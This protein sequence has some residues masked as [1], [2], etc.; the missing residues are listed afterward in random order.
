MATPPFH[1]PDAL[2]QRIADA[3]CHEK[4]FPAYQPIVCLRTRAI[5]GLEVLA[6]WHDPEWGNVPPK[7]FIP[8]ALQASLLPLLTL[9]LVRRACAEA[10]AWPGHFCLAFNVPPSLLQDAP[11]VRLLLEAMATSSFPLDR[12]CIEMTEDE[13]IED[14]AAA[15]RAFGYLKSHGIRVALDD[16]GTGFSSMVRLS[17]FG[18]DELKIDGSLIERLA[19]DRES[20][21]VVSA[22]IGLGHSLEVPVV[23][24]CVETEAQADVLRELGCDFVQGWLTGRPVSGDQAARLIAAAPVHAASPASLPLSPYLRQ[25]QLS[26]LYTNAP[27]GLAFLDLDMR[28][29]AANMQFARMAG[30]P[31]GEIVDAHVE[32]VYAPDIAAWILQASRRILDSGEVSRIEFRFPGREETFLVVGTR[33]TDET[34]QPIGVSVVTIDITDR[35][36]AEDEMRDR[37]ALYRA[38]VELG[39]NVLWVSGAD[40]TLTYISPAPQEPEG[41]AMEARMAAWYA[42]MH[43]DDV[44]RVRAEWS[45]AVQTQDAF[46]TRFRL[47]W[48][49]DRWR[50]VSSRAT[51]RTA[52]DGT[53][54]WFGVFTD[55]S[56]QVEL[57][58][59]LARHARGTGL[60]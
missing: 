14:D 47:R 55:I 54:S 10:S 22:I 38:V 43:D 2:R 29:A 24:E 5:H 3:V 51:Q 59:Q 4:I 39:P 35:K 31:L 48:F 25:H 44:P 7:D 28:Y 56:R 33:V 37:D 42:R 20:R 50:W 19:I 8:I 23:A 26:S 45:R 27:V 17:R 53:R 21:K 16:F 13:L 41:C 40:G 49:D 11:A 9:N 46:E 58:D 18:F 6:R 1:A 32:Q 34:A 12:I 52:A 60:P 36:R 15:E 57:E 30:R